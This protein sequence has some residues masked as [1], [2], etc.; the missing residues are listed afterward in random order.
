MKG[1]SQKMNYTGVS[2]GSP[3]RASILQPGNRALETGCTHTRTIEPLK[4]M[5]TFE[6][7][8]GDSKE[9]FFFIL[10]YFSLVFQH[11]LFKKEIY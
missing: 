4:T 10:F 9:T 8:M 1:S 5:G 2:E 7:R 6:C 3:R 11:S